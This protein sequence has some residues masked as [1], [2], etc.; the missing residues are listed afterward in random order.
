PRTLGT[1]SSEM[2]Q[3]A[4]PD[5]RPDRGVASFPGGFASVFSV[6]GVSLNVP[7]GRVSGFPGPVYEDRLGVGIGNF[8]L[9]H[10]GVFRSD[11]LFD[12]AERDRQEDKPGGE[13]PLL[14]PLRRVLGSPCS[15]SLPGKSDD[16]L[17]D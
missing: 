14:F 13:Q 17:L 11:R 1:W 8:L 3:R 2:A 5:P 4:D 9:D 12:L 15:P 7:P 6:D 16:P 10:V